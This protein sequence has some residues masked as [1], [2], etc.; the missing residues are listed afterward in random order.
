MKNRVLLT[1]P[2]PI[3]MPIIKI[4]GDSCNLKCEYCFYRKKNQDKKTIMSFCILEKFIK[5]YLELFDGNLRFTWHGGEPLLAGYDFFEKVVAFQE[6]YSHKSHKILNTVQTNGTLINKRWALLFKRYGFKIGV[7][8]DGNEK[9]HNLLRKNKANKGSFQQA[10]RG[11]RILQEYKVPVSILSTLTSRTIGHTKEN[12]SFFADTLGIKNIGTSIFY[13]GESDRSNP[14]NVQPEELTTHMKKT[15]DFWLEQN[16]SDFRVRE[17]ENYLAGIIGK[18]ASLCQ[19]NGWCT[20]FFCV[21]HDGKIYP[22]DRFSGQEDLL[23]GDLSAQPLI[24]ILNNPKRLEYFDKTSFLHRDCLECEWVNSCHNDCVSLRNKN[25]KSIFCQTRKQT[26]KY[27]R[28]K[29]GKYT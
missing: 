11:I 19:F 7:S 3:M 6:K 16:K 22:C 1:S 10:I 15:I 4:S 8:L 20:S 25:G 27:L 28:S 2:L 13:S 24:K 14:L 12:L 26:F 23:F 9:N 29:I 18:E 21:N 5:E 17:I